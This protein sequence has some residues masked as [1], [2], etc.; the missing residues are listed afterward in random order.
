[1]TTIDQ[2]RNDLEC[3]LDRE[4]VP[5][6]KNALKIYADLVQKVKL[7]I[8]ARELMTKLASGE[9]DETLANAVRALARNADRN[10]SDVQKNNL[11]LDEFNRYKKEVEMGTDVA[12]QA[13]LHLENI[14]K[15]ET[16]S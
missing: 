14:E 2:A 13:R 11:L 8:A 10:S 6:I 5:D 12:L 9:L 15:I 7:Q 4:N 3:A 16:L 1:M